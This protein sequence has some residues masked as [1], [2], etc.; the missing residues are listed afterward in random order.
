MLIIM[1]NTKFNIAQIRYFIF[2]QYENNC[3][4]N[5]I[6][7]P[8]PR[9]VKDTYENHSHLFQLTAEYDNDNQ[10]IAKT[11]CT[12]NLIDNERHRSEA[13]KLSFDVANRSQI[14]FFSIS[15]RIEFY[16]RKSCQTLVLFKSRVQLSFSPRFITLNRFKFLSSHVCNAL[17]LLL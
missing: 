6:L 11:H 15:P 8:H 5:C 17:A 1:M 7:V 14:L 12:Y 4:N 10:F 16:R 3:L 13:R 2:T 9:F